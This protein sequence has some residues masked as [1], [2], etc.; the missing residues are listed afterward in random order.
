LLPDTHEWSRVALAVDLAAVALSYVA[1]FVIA[2]APGGL[3]AREIALKLA[4]TPQFTP[5]F[6]QQAAALA[7]IV[8]LTLR[9]T[10]TIA[11]VL[12]GLLLYLKKPAIRPTQPAPHSWHSE[13]IHA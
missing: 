11:E 5:V 4:L 2:V 8:A 10:W 6:G 12:V 1:G 9:L 3:G 13:T 7:V